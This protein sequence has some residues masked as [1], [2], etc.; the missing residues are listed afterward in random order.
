MRHLKNYKLFEAISKPEPKYPV[1]YKCLDIEAVR[2]Q[3]EEKSGLDL[4]EIPCKGSKYGSM[5][6]FRISC[7]LTVGFHTESSRLG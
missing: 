5:D 7:T 1:N 2:E 4:S 3:I 6:I